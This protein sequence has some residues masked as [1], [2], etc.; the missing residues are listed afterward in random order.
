MSAAS[1]DETNVER[2]AIPSGQSEPPAHRLITHSI[3]NALGQGIPIATAVVAV[4][5]ILRLY[6]N[7]RLG[8]LTLAWSVIGYASLFD[9]GVGRALTQV[10]A[11]RRHASNESDLASLIW[12]SLAALVLVGAMFGAAGFA[13]SHW[14]ATSALSVTP[15]LQSDFQVAVRLLAVGVPIVVVTTGVR[16]VLEAHERF[17]LVNAVRVPLGVSMFVGPL[18]AAPFARTLWAAVGAI[19]VTRLV[20]LGIYVAMMRRVVPAARS[21]AR[22][23]LPHLRPVARFGAWM[24]V[25]NVLSPL[26]TQADR[27]LIGAILSTSV[28]AYYTA[29]NEMVTR[30]MG[31]VAIAVATSIF[32]AFARWRDPAAAR[33]L[34]LR[35][36]KLTAVAFVPIMLGLIVFADV[37]LR[38]WLGADFSA[39][40]ALVLRIL[41]AGMLFNGLA[42]IPFAHI[43]AVGR[44]DLTAKIHLAE[45]PLYLIGALFLI[46]DFGIAG[47]AIAWS[48][49]ATVDAMLLFIVSQR[50]IAGSDATISAVAARA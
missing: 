20:A 9:F 28:V 14:I 4:P 32:P 16:G 33:A 37:V 39:H 10:V 29:P 18:V 2:A 3:W 12:S 30:I 36:L 19:L 11:E 22:L 6:G 43:Q 8:L 35:G 44:A 15:A 34:F 45:C 46:R 17:D 47:A 48:V 1:P 49:R 7:E 42:Q 38:L 24:T 5:L 50:L 40:S 27:F 23:S 13:L 21:V 25:S 31:A 41:S 26:M